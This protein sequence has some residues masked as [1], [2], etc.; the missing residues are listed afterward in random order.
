MSQGGVSSLGSGA[1]SVTTLTG[2]GGGAVSPSGGGNIN[3]VGTGIIN[4]TGNPGTNT[5][6]ISSGA[7]SLSYTNVNSTPYVVL[8][9]DY[10]ISVDSSGGVRTIELPNAATLGQAFVIKDRTGSS[11]SNNITITTVGGAVL[12][13][14][15]TSVIINSAYESLNIIGNSVGYELF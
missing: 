5:L 9:T 12:I 11:P 4:V 13:D 8:I 10:Y 6:T 3:I 14:G 1:G 15:S 2:N 7:A